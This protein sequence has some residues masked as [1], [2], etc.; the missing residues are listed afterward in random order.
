MKRTIIGLL[1]LALT[2][3]TA[4]P[5]AAA[6]SDGGSAAV[7]PRPAGS[8]TTNV[9]G[10]TTN[11]V[12]TITGFDVVDGALVAVGTITGTV[13]TLVNGVPTVTQV[14]NAPFTAIVSPSG[15]CDILTLDLGPI[16]L[17]VLGLIVDVSAISV[18]IVADPGA[19]N[20]L[21]NL[22]CAVAHLLDGNAPLG[23]LAALLDRILGAL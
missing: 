13:T 20:L 1:A 17:D 10:A 6:Q 8:I 16:D 3:G 2:L 21:G 9:V 19:G 7:A 18:D 12:A 14:T 5:A 23:G 15:T 4:A 22:L 11:A